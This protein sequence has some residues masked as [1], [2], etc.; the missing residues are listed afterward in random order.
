M[1]FDSGIVVIPHAAT[2][3]ADAQVAPVECLGS[4]CDRRAELAAWVIT[5]PAEELAELEDWLKGRDQLVRFRT[6]ARAA[7]AW[8]DGSK[9]EFPHTEE[10]DEVGLVAAMLAH[11]VGETEALLEDEEATRAQLK[12][13]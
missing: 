13:V 1:S 3:E 4:A 2:V 5:A 6:L 11:L 10:D 8:V 7:S 9:V 12:V